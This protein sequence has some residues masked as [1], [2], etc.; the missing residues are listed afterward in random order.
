MIDGAGGRRDRRLTLLPLV[1]VNAD[2]VQRLLE[3]ADVI[4]ENKFRL[5]LHCSRSGPPEGQAN[6]AFNISTEINYQREE[7]TKIIR[8][9]LNFKKKT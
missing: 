1:A 3:V 8:Y 7:R 6:R 5:L 2:A 9:R 4:V